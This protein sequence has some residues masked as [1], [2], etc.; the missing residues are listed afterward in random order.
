MQNALCDAVVVLFNAVVA[1]FNAVVALSDAV[2]VFFNAVV[3]LSD[4]GAQDKWCSC[5]FSPTRLE[6]TGWYTSHVIRYPIDPA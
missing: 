3:A 5:A 1:L 6:R 4:M 2:V